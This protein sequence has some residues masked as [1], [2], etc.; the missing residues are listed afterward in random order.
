MKRAS[1]LIMLLAMSVTFLPACRS[2]K[3]ST[4]I[5][6]GGTSVG[7]TVA[8]TVATAIG[9]VLLSKLVNSVL[10]TV[11]GSKAFSNLS[12]NPQFTS[13]FNE[14]TKLASFANNDILK[15]GLQVLVSQRYQIPLATVANNYSSLLTVGDLATFIGKNASATAL[16]ELK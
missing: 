7:G 16:Q 10:K 9:L 1:V 4:G 5:L 13:N 15:T 14:N 3:S 12:Q 8:K 11:T 2:S 6:G